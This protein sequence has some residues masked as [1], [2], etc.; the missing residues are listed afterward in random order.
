MEKIT[1]KMFDEWAKNNGGCPYSG[2][3][4]RL[5]FFEPKKEAWTTEWTPMKTSDLIIRICD[6][7]KWKIVLPQKRRKSILMKS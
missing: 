6:E 7:K 4:E 3:V 1:Q 5:H 2:C